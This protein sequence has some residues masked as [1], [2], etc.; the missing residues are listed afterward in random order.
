[1]K[2]VLLWRKNSDTRTLSYEGQLGSLIYEVLMTTHTTFACCNALS[3]YTTTYFI[4][5]MFSSLYG[6]VSD[7]IGVDRNVLMI[8]SRR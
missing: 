8:I 3:N 4:Y 6:V 5:W 7:V 1:M 2:L